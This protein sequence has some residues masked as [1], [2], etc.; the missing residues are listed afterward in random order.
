MK[1]SLKA[2][3]ISQLDVD[4]LNLFFWENELE[5]SLRDIPTGLISLIKEAEKREEFKGGRDE[6]LILSSKGLISSYKLILTGLGK[7]NDFNRAVLA[8]QVAKSIRKSKENKAVRVGLVLSDDGFNKLGVKNAVQTIVEAV[9]LST[10]RFLKYKSEEER[11][12]IREIEEVIVAVSPGRLSLAEEGI[13]IGK[14]MSIA[15]LYAR[16][17]V[18]EPSQVTTPT[19]LADEAIRLGKN[20]QGLLK[21]TVLDKEEIEKLGMNSFLGVAKGSDEPPKFIILKYKPARPKKKLVIIGKGITFDTG[22]LSLKPAE[23]METMKLDMAGAASILGIFSAFPSFKPS[24]EVV[25]LIAACENM[26]SGKAL[27]PGDI[28]K[29]LNGKTIEVLNTD[30]E[31]RLTLADALSYAVKQEKPDE[32]ID[33]ATLTGACQVALGQDIAGLFGNNESLLHSLERA[34]KETGEQVWRMP[35]SEQYKELNK[36]KIADIK[37]IQTGRYGGAITAALFLQEF[38]GTTAWAHL[39]IAGPAYIEKD[40]PLTPTGGA[41]FG[42]RLVLHYINTL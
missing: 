18:N 22:G 41:G 8:E 25:G 42:V 6:I 2:S 13:D 24:V 4:S 37:N 14:S 35:L 29:A 28:L 34:S 39:D 17:L 5:K 36:S 10:Y 38:V 20:S 9:F 3:K 23:H 30:A 33:L 15:A 12:K 19:F 1:I 31:G 7:K 27:K 40:T 16:D 21:V 11:N 32:I 26:P